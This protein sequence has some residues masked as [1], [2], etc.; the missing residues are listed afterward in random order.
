MRYIRNFY[1]RWTQAFQEWLEGKLAPADLQPVID[2]L[3]K[4]AQFKR[5][6]AKH[7]ILS[8]EFNLHMADAEL[9]AL[10]DWEYKHQPER[11]FQ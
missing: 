10:D 9:A 5:K 8:H 3:R 11:S 6:C 4:D 7:V 1:E 2:D